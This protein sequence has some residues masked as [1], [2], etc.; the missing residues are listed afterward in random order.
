VTET[1][2]TGASGE[3]RETWPQRNSSSIRSPITRMRCR[4]KAATMS[5]R[6]ME[7][8]AMIANLRRS[9]A[10][11][12][13]FRVADR[14]RHQGAAQGRT[15]QSVSQVHGANDGPSEYQA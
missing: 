12:A 5:R 2:G 11:D 15:P 13:P 7:P 10:G 9:A 14:F 8:N 1:M 3:M 4:L 6:S